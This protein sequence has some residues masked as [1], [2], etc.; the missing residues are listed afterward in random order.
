MLCA[1]TACTT[2]VFYGR[3]VPVCRIHEA[4]YERWGDDAEEQAVLQWDWV[5]PASAKDDAAIPASM[6]LSATRA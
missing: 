2:V 3:E 5:P 6:S 4:K 1:S